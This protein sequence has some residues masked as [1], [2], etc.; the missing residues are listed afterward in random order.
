M[1][2]PTAP[3]RI[4]PRSDL[5]R[6]VLAGEPTIGLFIGLGSAVSAEIVARAGYDWTVVDLEHGSGTESELLGQL[7]AIQATPGFVIK[8]VAILG[9]PG[10][11]ALQ[12]VIQAVQRCDNVVCDG[13]PR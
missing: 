3:T 13:A 1:T 12:K 10:K 8:S 9:Y 7:L 5:R 6:R 11:G 2:H 4:P